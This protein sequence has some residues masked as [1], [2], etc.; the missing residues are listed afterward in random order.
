MDKNKQ[1]LALSASYLCRRCEASELPF[2][3]TRELEHLDNYFGQE[4]ATEALNF[5]V[6]IEHEG[7]NIFVLGPTGMGRHQMVSNFVGQFAS[8]R[9]APTDWCYV[10]NFEAPHQPRV[11]ALP[12]GMARQL[13]KDMLQ[14]IEDL[15]VSIPG[16]FQSVEYK[17]RVNEINREYNDK[18]Q[19]ALGE[20]EEK[21]RE[22]NISLIQTP[23]GYTLAPMV[24]G[25]VITSDEFNALSEEERKRI[26]VVTSTLKEELKQ[27]V[28]KM[29]VWMKA[30]REQLKKLNREIV[31][32]TVKQVFA[33]QEQ[34]YRELP[35]VMSFLKAVEQDVVENV[36]Y[37]NM[38]ERPGAPDDPKNQDK[39][40]PMYTV[41]VLVDN[42]QCSGA[43][44]VYENNPSLS[45]LLG[46]VEHEAQ[47]GTL[48]T[49]FT[50]IKAGAL[51]KANGGY[52]LLDAVKLLTSPFAWD[53]L[54]R[55]LLSRE[56]KIESA[57]EILSLASTKSLEPEAIPLD[58]KV[59]LVGDR[60]IYYLLQAYDPEF[61]Q[62]FKVPAD[63]SEE[64]DRNAQNSLSFARLI[65]SLQH[66]EG[67]RPL[68]RDAVARVIE[69]SSRSLEDA[70]KLS[71]HLNHL[72]DLICESDFF[73]AQDKAD[74]ITRA[75]V[76]RAID[77]ANRRLDQFR[78][79]VH[80]S[81][82]R[83]IQLVDTEGEQVAQVNGLSVYQLGEYSFGRPSR[84]TAKARLGSGKVLDIE[85][86][87]KL[88]GNIH[89]KAVMILSSLMANRY[90]RNKPL[91]V[92]ASLV[93]EQ[94]YGGVEG[95]SASIAEFCT[96]VSAIAN[97]PVQ[98]SLAVT[99][100]LNQHGQAQAIGGINQKIEGYFDICLARGLTG[101]QGVLMPQANVQH[102][103]LKQAVVDAVE[104]GEFNIYAVENIDQALTL[105]MEM[106]AGELQTDG[107]Y[108]DDSVNGRVMA[109][110]DAWIELS[111]KYS[112]PA[113]EERSDDKQH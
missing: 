58:L 21:A 75:H 65:A 108:P 85:R 67:H 95:D 83:D 45:N 66:K 23:T 56:A 7:Y 89:S 92:S 29:P 6:S 96:L 44:V 78:E 73:A 41:N 88:G 51:H 63:L 22:Q 47:Y 33:D 113:D 82:L 79:K 25:R 84:I 101:K 42:S 18:E 72:K 30:G 4:R 36:N 103:M 90:A 86:A 48:T 39:A 40:F 71:L 100:S 1:A 68:A 17:T 104:R 98:Q 50:L 13:E 34:S 53:A 38:E 81:I 107:R 12:A 49:N 106:P 3:D 80:E 109:Q 52:L 97:I 46:R 74:I 9:P 26:E 94:S 35:E 24:E 69:Q 112:A 87:V 54:K 91:P 105:L 110:I 55:A 102:L 60:M 8:E 11:L 2:A 99:G 43:P 27:I 93:F 76:Q 32:S 59:I 37:F 19:R 14:C 20:L 5:G 16:V 10:N 70:E 77:A 15:L 64:I 111:K 61:N 57:S 31:E 62:L 28:M